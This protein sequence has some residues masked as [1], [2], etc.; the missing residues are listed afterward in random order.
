MSKIKILRIIAR[1]NIGGPAI[2]VNLLSTG[3]KGLGYET[4]LSAGSVGE[5]EGIFF[6]PAVSLATNFKEIPTLGREINFGADFK[7]LQ[8]I[9]KIIRDFRPQIIHTHTAKA[10]FLGRVAA[11][12]EGVPLVFHT[13]HGHVLSGYFSP[14]KEKVFRFIEKALAK[15]TDLIIAVSEKVADDL[16]SIGVA[17]K[18]KIKVVPLGLQLDEYLSV[19]LHGALKQEL[20][21]PNDSILIGAVG[22]LAPV[23]N[24]GFLI[25]CFARLEKKY[26]KIRLALVGDGPDRCLL[27]A[28]ARE[29]NVGARVFFLGWRRDLDYVYGGLDVVALTSINEGTPVSIIEALAC[30]RPV[31]AT[32]VGGVPEVLEF[33]GLGN[34]VEPGNQAGFCQALEKVILD[35]KPAP[36]SDRKRVVENYSV[37][38]LVKTMDSLYHQFLDKKLGSGAELIS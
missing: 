37:S 35:P 25:Q 7:S 5:R 21:V 26:P 15:K 2:H 29:L 1:L 30:G 31:V 6:K 10:G 24:L 9:R 33:G 4:M 14:F 3:L 28:L 36:E 17:N 18:S 19:K 22:R 12:L 32:A 20:A 38:K 16:E 13:F 8:E 34:L 23:K 27:E 11:I